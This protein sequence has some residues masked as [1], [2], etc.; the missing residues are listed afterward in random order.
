MLQPKSISVIA[1]RVVNYKIHQNLAFVS[2]IENSISVS[3]LNSKI[4]SQ[5]HLNITGRAGLIYY[6]C[7]MVYNSYESVLGVPIFS[8]V[9]F[10]V[11]RT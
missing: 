10:A 6:R 7:F 9:F 1:P 2:H 5:L 11:L 8:N 4:Y 3:I